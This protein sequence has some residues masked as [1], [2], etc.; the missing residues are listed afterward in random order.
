[1]RMA[2]SQKNGES[3]WSVPAARFKT[4][5][6]EVFST[7]MVGFAFGRCWVYIVFFNIAL[8]VSQTDTHK[9]LDSLYIASLVTLV[10]VLVVT[11]I[12]NERCSSLMNSRYGV[13]SGAA[14]SIIGTSAFPF[15]GINNPEQLVF[16]ALSAVATG[17]GSGLLLLFWGKMYSRIGGPSAAAE[18]SVAFILATLPVP[19]FLLAP[20]ALQVAV[21]TL[22]PIASTLVLI[23]ELKKV[24]EDGHSKT[25]EGTSRPWQ[26]EI[27]GLDQK[28]LTL[29]IVFSS[30]VFGCVVSLTRAVCTNQ[31]VIEFGIGF[32]IILPVSALCAGGVTLCVLFFSRRLDLAFTY[33]PVLIFMS[34][35]CCLL[36]VFYNSGVVAYFLAMTGYLCFEIMN[37]VILSDASFRFGIPPFRIFS[38]G[39]ASVSG[40]VLIGAVLGSLLNAV[41]DYSLEFIT[42]IS[43]VMVFVMIVTYTFTLTER[44]VAKL[45]KQRSQ[46]PFTHQDAADRSLLLDERVDILAKRHDISGRGLEV[47]RLLAKGWTGV[48]IEQELYM[49]RGTVNTHMRRLYQKLG[50]HTRQNL[51]DM[52]DKIKNDFRA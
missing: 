49:S 50:V 13:W 24:K 4:F 1:M 2:K 15:S 47:L 37:W 16:L 34:L 6:Q 29:K 7:R 23:R 3:S 10:V 5:K 9:T 27:V 40:G 36:P 51:L 41:V 52:L 30:I 46:Y 14:F 26:L 39:R 48:R 31:G 12:A 11:G 8:L 43:L 18:S 22:L 32:N 45:T 17:I 33:R 38:F 44:D 21:V 28:Q 25:E 20:F 19:F 35:G 42:G